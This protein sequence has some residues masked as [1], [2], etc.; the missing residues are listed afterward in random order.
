MAKTAKVSI[1]WFLVF[2]SGL[3]LA[4]CAATMNLV[5]YGTMKTDVSMG[6]TVFLS[7]VDKD[8]K[9]VYLSVHNTSR[10]Q[11]ITGDLRSE[12]ASG[13]RE[14]GYQI[15]NMPSRADYILQANIR[16]E[17]RWKQGMSFGDTLSGTGIGALSG[18]GL[19][20]W[21]SATS[22]LA[23]GFVG[24]AVGF[25]ADAATR[26]NTEVILVDLRITER[27]A[28]GE[29]ITG[30]KVHESDITSG[31]QTSGGIGT[32]ASAPA[33]EI[34]PTTVSSSR[35]GVKTYDTAIA[36][37]AMQVHLSSEKA[38]AKLVEIAGREI[39]GIF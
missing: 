13:L 9:T 39:A 17:G 2:V 5:D 16:Y 3:L 12:I 25:L 35:E 28:R 10:N 38:S 23:G 30:R 18:L 31:E 32:H 24:G 11:N 22:T 14:K 21:R 19:S 7:P 20:G 34:T 1:L 4:G 37:K 6:K 27:L 36:A 8:V 29:D 26:V 33:S 15:V